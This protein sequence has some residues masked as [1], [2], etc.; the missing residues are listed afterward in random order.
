MTNSSSVTTGTISV[1]APIY[2][3]VE[4]LPRLIE[5][6]ATVMKDNGYFYEIVCVDDGSSDG[7][8]ALLKQLAT[9]RSDLRAI[10]LRRNYG[11]TPA[12]AAGFENV[13]G[14]VVISLDADLQNDPQ[15][16]PLLLKKMD[17]DS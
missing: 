11:Q 10:L 1:I 14:D 15:D 12:M 2:N 5:A 8:T 6:I 3:E 9:E 4:S 13:L 7:S 17:Q 16:I